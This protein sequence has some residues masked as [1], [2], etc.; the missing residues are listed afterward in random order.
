[1]SDA[2]LKRHAT[3]ESIRKA[4]HADTVLTA[5]NSIAGKVTLTFNDGIPPAIVQACAL[6][7][8]QATIK[9][10]EVY[11]T[12]RDLACLTNAV[13]T[14]NENPNLSNDELLEAIKYFKGTPA[15]I[16]KLKLPG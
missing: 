10:N 7:L 8:I 4:L 15:D 9:D 1:M 2:I 6:S 3:L 5:P 16:A 11:G 12:D 14:I 13:Q